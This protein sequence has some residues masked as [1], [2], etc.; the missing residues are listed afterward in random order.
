V[1]QLLYLP[2]VA[3]GSEYQVLFDQGPEGCDYLLVRVERGR[4]GGISPDE[5]LERW[6]V[7]GIKHAMQVS[8]SVELVEQGTL[9][10]SERKTKRMFDQRIFESF[11]RA[12]FPCGSWN[13]QTG[14]GAI[15]AGVVR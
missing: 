12:T 4:G 10:R 7:A 15:G 3:T 1:L 5:K 6:G 14:R 13:A 8:S 11:W 2:G 9:P